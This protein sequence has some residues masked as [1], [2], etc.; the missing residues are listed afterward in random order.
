MTDDSRT[1]D[2]NQIAEISNDYKLLQART[3]KAYIATM[4]D[5]TNTLNRC[6]H[7]VLEG[8]DVEEL[9]SQSG[10]MLYYKIKDYEEPVPV[11]LQF[12]S[13]LHSHLKKPSLICLKR[14]RRVLMA[15]HRIA[16]ATLEREQMVG[17]AHPD[18]RI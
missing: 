18:P 15:Q 12:V 1:I 16:L 9:R 8:I 2:L 4:V 3:S 10:H 14:I 11:D 17:R 5:I 6:P 13:Q 7:G